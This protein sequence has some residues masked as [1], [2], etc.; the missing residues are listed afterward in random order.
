M[1]R[2]LERDEVFVDLL[3]TISIISSSYRNCVTE[4]F[5]SSC[6]F[7]GILGVKMSSL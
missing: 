5:K 2:G 4:W 6:L 1:D 3:R 7:Y